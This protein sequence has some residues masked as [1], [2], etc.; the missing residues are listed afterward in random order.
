MAVTAT[1]FGLDIESETPLALLDWSERTTHR[2]PARR[3]GERGSE[4]AMAIGLASACATTFS[5]TAAS[6]TRSRRDPEAG[7]LISGPEYGTHL[8]SR[9]GRLLQCD[10]EGAP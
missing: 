2:P 1:A 4:A 8:L 5:P 3:L 7:Y 6:S 10:P 9:D